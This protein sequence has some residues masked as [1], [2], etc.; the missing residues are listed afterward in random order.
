MR[1]FFA[2]SSS[3]FNAHEREKP[4]P[5]AYVSRI[6]TTLVHDTLTLH[7]VW[8]HR[9]CACAKH[10]CAIIIKAHRVSLDFS[11]CSR[12]ITYRWCHLATVIFIMTRQLFIWSYALGVTFNPHWDVIRL[13]ILRL[14][15]AEKRGVRLVSV[16]KK[17]DWSRANVQFHHLRSL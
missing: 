6:Q 2:V 1:M 9:L 13:I 5:P 4:E 16:L 11:L 12:R 7:S 14:E 8:L 17:R 3:I 10:H 15:L